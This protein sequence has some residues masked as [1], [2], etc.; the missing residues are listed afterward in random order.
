VSLIEDNLVA[1]VV[2]ATGVSARSVVVSITVSIGAVSLEVGSG[3]YCP[4]VRFTGVRTVVLATAT[5]FICV[6]LV[7]GA[8]AGHRLACGFL[9]SECIGAIREQVRFAAGSCAGVL[10]VLITGSTQWDDL[11]PKPG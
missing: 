8:P 1:R 5:I 3:V 10:V 9:H 11:Q 2:L 7:A 6:V 4:C